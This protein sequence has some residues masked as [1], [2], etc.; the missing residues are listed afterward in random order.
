M[1]M[2]FQVISA[3]IRSLFEYEFDPALTMK[4]SYGIIRLQLNCEYVRS[5][6]T[7]GVVSNK[8]T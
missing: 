5:P 3:Y 8:T 6:Q 2:S 1:T 7:V 4:A